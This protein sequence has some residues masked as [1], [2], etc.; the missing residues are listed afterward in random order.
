MVGQRLQA[1]VLQHAGNFF[2]AL[3]RL[4]VDDAGFALVLGLDETQQLA[5]R[6]GLLDDGVADVGPVEAADELAR[7]LQLEALDHVLARQRVGRGRQRH[8]RHV[9]EGLVQQAQ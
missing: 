7:V 1:R 9:G 3:A 8:A 2:H 6:V 4:A 5:R